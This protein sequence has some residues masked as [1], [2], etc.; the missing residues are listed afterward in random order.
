MVILKLLFED[1]SNLNGEF[2]DGYLKYYKWVFQM[3]ISNEQRRNK[4]GYSFSR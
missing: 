1:L 2:E 3:S 4:S